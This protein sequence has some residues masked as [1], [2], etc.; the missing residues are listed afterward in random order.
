M[1]DQAYLGVLL[2]CFNKAGVQKNET[3][4]IFLRNNEERGVCFMGKILSIVITLVVIL[5]L[6][7]V[8]SVYL[9]AAFIDYSFLV[10]LIMTLI[11]GFFTSKGGFT[12]QNNNM[13][14]QSQTM[15]KMEVEKLKLTPTYAFYTAIIYTIVSL[16]LTIYIYKDYF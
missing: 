9:N 8:V 10:G 6:N 5:G 4:S 16:I 15:Y 12:T 1:G 3:F 2:V 11:I 14:V 13:L 7:Y